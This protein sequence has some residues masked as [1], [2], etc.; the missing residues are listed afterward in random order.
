MGAVHH[1]AEQEHGF[2]VRSNWMPNMIDVGG[3]SDRLVAVFGVVRSG[4]MIPA[5]MARRLLWALLARGVDTD[6]RD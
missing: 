2:Q 5:L 4:R 6:H 1:H 3:R